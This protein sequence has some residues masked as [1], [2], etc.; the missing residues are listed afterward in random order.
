MTARYCWRTAVSNDE[1]SAAFWAR[2]HTCG[3]LREEDGGTEVV[4]NGWINT[5]RNLGGLIFIDVRDRH[6]ITQVLFDPDVVDEATFELAGSLRSEFVVAVKGSVHVRSEGQRNSRVATG[7][8]EVVASGLQ[9]LTRSEPLPIVLDGKA[10]ASE[11]L[12]L[13]YRYLDLRRDSLQTNL[14]TRHRVCLATRSY[15]DGHGFIEVETPVLTKSTPEGARDY[16]VPSR[17]QPGTF[18]ALPQSPQLFK[19]ILMISGYDRYLQIVKCFR[20]E[21][22]RADRQPEFTQVDIEISFC[23][24][25]VLFP[26]L[27]GWVALMW[28]EFRGIDL[29]LPLPRMDYAH[30]MEHFGVDRPDLRFDLQMATVDDLVAE[31]GD[32]PLRSALDLDDGAVKAMFVPGDPAQLSRKLLD[33][34]TTLVRDFGLGGLL[35]GKVTKEGCSGAAGKFLTEDQRAAIIGRLGE[36]NGFDAGSTGILMLAAGREA[37]VNDAFY[38]LRLKLGADLD[39]IDPEAFA[40]T[41]V[42]DFP[43]FQ[44]S[45]TD[46]RWTSMHHPF[47]SPIPE[48]F[49]LLE[50]NPGE[51]M[52]DA[53]DLV[54]NGLELGG[55]SI[56][57]HDPK[58]QSLV[59]RAL[60]IEEEEARQKFGFLLDALSYGTPPHGGIAF[61]L[62]RLVM[63]LAGTEAIR[64]VIAF[65]KTQRASCLMTAAPG[66]VD[67]AQMNELHLESTATAS[68][69]DEDAGDQATD[70]PGGA[71]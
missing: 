5:N 18:F 67:Q 71:S 59:F 54:C 69:D 55:G 14:M 56:R 9:L 6:G 60:G 39:L 64:D 41:W 19:Q 47:T 38:R 57:I 31:A 16:L 26:I 30:A 58:I 12:R 1:K 29:P 50:T 51:V 27:E 24:K 3:D 33:G 44:W 22:L 52:S 23:T 37:T 21:D 35:W 40:F 45:E 8:V 63:L 65:P 17:V 43:A 62:D 2:T 66:P 70:A 49:E 53:Y 48:H 7:S 36:R 42:T 10:E 68:A 34:Y 28:K 46:E 11:E 32:G 61:G 20:D 13:K 4:L 25:D 15:F